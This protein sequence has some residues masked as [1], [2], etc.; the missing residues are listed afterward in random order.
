M[1]EEW[2]TTPAAVKSPTYHPPC[3]PVQGWV[4]GPVIRVTGIR[5]AMAERFAPPEPVPDR[6]ELYAATSWSPACPQNRSPLIE[7]MCGDE[8]LADLLED[9][10]CQR[11]SITR[12]ADVGPDQLLPVMV[13]VHGG[14]YVSGAGDS[15]L[16]DPARLV[17][18]QRVI[19]V[20]VTYRLG[21]F[22]Y[23]G[24]DGRAAN[25]GLLDQREAFRWV[26]R[27]IAAFGG[28]P[29]SITAFGE[30]AGAD[31]V[32]H[33]LAAARG[34]RLFRRA[35]VQSA[36]LGIR[37]A[38]ERM[39]EVMARAARNPRRP[40]ALRTDTPV[41][42]VLVRQRSVLR[43][44][45]R[46]G[47]R[48]GMA[49]GVQYGHPPLPP[50]DEVEATWDAEA[51][52]DLMIGTND[53]ESSFFIPGLAPLR[54]LWSVPLVGRRLVAAVVD[55]TTRAV[56]GAAADDFAD[57]HARAG[58]VAYRYHLSWSA[59]GNR[60]GSTHGIDLALLFGREQSWGDAAMLAGAGWDE[61]ERAGQAIRELW[62]DFARGR[63]LS[64]T[65]SI[66]GVLSLARR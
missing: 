17:A 44:A 13:W 56:Y 6:T 49:F 10:H 36:P 4:D 60:F 25:L 45:A 65:S 63:E 20:A 9:E 33:L 19:V 22:G 62:G 51:H 3:G 47:L 57:R 55:R 23:L 37:T 61:I 54:L 42:A 7:H 53:D 11:L 2:V 66:P 29:D 30:S 46:F 16:T 28:D 5:Y 21:L 38:R 40:G 15:P 18:E 12:P 26:A 50:E 41:A 14:S 52:V 32:V 8:G 31:A 39:T 35:I 59:P 58:G 64:A 24:A 43:S 48:A 34:E 27:N 1:Y